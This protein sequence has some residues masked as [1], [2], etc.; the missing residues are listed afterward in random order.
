VENLEPA[1]IT[2]NETATHIQQKFV[3]FTPWN[4]KRKAQHNLGKT[5]KCTIQ[6]SFVY[7]TSLIFLLVLFINRPVI[8]CS[9]RSS[10]TD[11]F[12]KQDDKQ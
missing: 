9:Q 12:I 3:H 4:C 8:K 5:K 1:P 10:N 11:P 2:T 7:C 6:N